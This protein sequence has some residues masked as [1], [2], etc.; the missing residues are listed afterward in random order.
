MSS[1]RPKISTAT[2]SGVVVLC[3][4]FIMLAERSWA[5]VSARN[6]GIWMDWDAGMLSGAGRGGRMAEP[7]GE[8]SPSVVELVGQR[9]VEHELWDWFSLGGI[10][11]RSLVE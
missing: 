3:L 10:E 1:G 11:S 8:A 9:L 6:R 4:A 5:L 2:L 7:G